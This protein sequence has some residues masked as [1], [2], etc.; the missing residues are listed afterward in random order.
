MPPL[1][2]TVYILLCLLSGYVGRRTR[3]GFWGA[4]VIAVFLTPLITLPV[5]F[6][7]GGGKPPPRQRI[8]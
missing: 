1:I 5:L 8:E 6:L 7:L 2:L 3:V 4:V